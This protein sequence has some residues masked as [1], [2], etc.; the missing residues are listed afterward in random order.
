[1]QVGQ[2]VST[3]KLNKLNYIEQSPAVKLPLQRHA[4]VAIQLNPFSSDILHYI[5]EIP[6]VDGFIVKFLLNL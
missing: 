1:M 4:R 6:S 3:A 2:Y 5:P